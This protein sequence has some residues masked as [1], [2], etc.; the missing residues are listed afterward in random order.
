MLR[1]HWF[2]FNSACIFILLATVLLSC[3]AV[4]LQIFVVIFRTQL[5][6]LRGRGA[7]VNR[8][9]GG[10]TVRDFFTERDGDEGGDDGVEGS[11]VEAELSIL[12]RLSDSRAPK[13]TVS[14]IG[15]TRR[16]REV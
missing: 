12:G 5:R 11:V 6:E 9:G 15:L 4:S 16:D 7:K 2:L 14:W 13:S 10:G 8:R 1:R 3:M